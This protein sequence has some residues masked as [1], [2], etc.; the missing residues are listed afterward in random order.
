MKKKIVLKSIFYVFILSCS[1]LLFAQDAYSDRARKYV[2][3]YKDWAIAE[4]RRTGVP[5]AI[6]LAQGIHETSGGQSEL[7][8]NA[9]N[10]FGIKCRSD[11]K[12][13]SY[14][15]SDDRPNEC[16][17]KYE[18]VLESYKDHSDYLSGS[19]RYASLFN[20]SM[21]DYVGWANGL[22]KYG[23]ATNP[24][25]AQIL[26]KIVEDYG[27]QEY[28]FAANEPIKQDKQDVVQ[29]KK[30][31]VENKEMNSGVSSVSTS[32]KIT[33][34]NSNVVEPSQ[35]SSKIESVTPAA[36]SKMMVS[37]DQTVE[38]QN[39]KYQYN[40]STEKQ[41]KPK[42]IS[43][44]LENETKQVD[45]EVKLVNGLKAFFAK[46]GTILLN[47]AIRF[48]IRYPK[49]L[50][51]NDLP[52]A[53]LEADM[54]IYLEKKHVVGTQEKYQ[55][56]KGETLL[57]IAQKLGIQVRFLKQYNN[58]SNDGSLLVGSYLYLNNSNV[59]NQLNKNKQTTLSSS[60]QVNS[61]NGN[62]QNKIAQKPK[63]TAV[64]TA[65]AGFKKDVVEPVKD[66]IPNAKANV[67]AVVNPVLSK[68]DLPLMDTLNYKKDTVE[69][70]QEIKPT[71][72][73]DTA[74]TVQEVQVAEVQVV[75]EPKKVIDP[76]IQEL[77]DLARE[78]AN[79][80]ANDE[81]AKMK[82]KL[83]KVVYA[84]EIKETDFSIPNATVVEEKST[85]VDKKTI[86]YR[87]KKGDT[88]FSIA[89]ENN[90]TV[91]QLKE[92][93]NLKSSLLKTGQKVK[94]N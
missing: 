19:P 54:P 45:A 83:D 87:V 8:A 51:L 82:E 7:A 20:L 34:T 35:S 70:V 68:L 23:Y 88:I 14:K 67:A 52:D 15:Y 84:D 80:D 53:P 63:P 37:Y 2:N 10:H 92:W 93:N 25:Y 32:S 28:T 40:Q 26:I 89:K 75:D 36:K 90:V 39:Y 31:K 58:L 12:G 50:E 3:Q 41:S 27:L 16:F 56:K 11:W 78:E 29:N 66:K 85:L 47:D 62:D 61:I 60:Q 57:Q 21:T 33:T 79:E 74:K 73:F 91:K 6:T 81:F 64:N 42:E 49:L 48:D 86:I 43:H 38:Q 94:I 46:K 65:I 18:S 5:A 76:S 1:N 69:I 55:I 30:I 77:I 59:Q 9:N 22:K 17:R 72:I 24:K 13:M 71:L 4:Q 44:K